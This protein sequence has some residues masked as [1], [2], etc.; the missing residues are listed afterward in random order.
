[1]FVE[2]E[3]VPISTLQGRNFWRDFQNILEKQQT[4]MLLLLGL[5][6]AIKV[7]VENRVFLRRKNTSK[8]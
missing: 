2:V 3:V 5:I 1:M 7:M 4:L 6:L 8:S